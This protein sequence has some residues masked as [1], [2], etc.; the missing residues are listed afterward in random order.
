MMNEKS[1]FIENKTLKW[2]GL[3]PESSLTLP[4]QYF[5]DEKIFKKEIE[6]IFYPSWHFV[7]HE[8]ELSNT[9]DFV[10]FDILRQSI[11]SFVQKTAA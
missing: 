11:L 9:G 6:K 3:N 1:F 10:K 7:C 4:S 2:D 5:F 8:S